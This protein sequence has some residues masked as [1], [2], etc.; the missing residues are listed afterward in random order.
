MLTGSGILR[1][2]EELS[3]W[4][5]WSSVLSQS[6]SFFK[7]CI[8]NTML[9]LV[10]LDYKDTYVYLIDLNDSRQTRTNLVLLV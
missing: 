2:S 5:L 4:I 3:P 1:Y 7:N 10:K 8:Q 9:A 6:T